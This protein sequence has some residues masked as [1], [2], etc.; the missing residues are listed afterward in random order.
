MSQH[1]S[2]KQQKLVVS[3]IKSW[4]ADSVIPAE[5]AAA[6]IGRY[7]PHAAAANIPGAL[8]IVGAVLVGLGTL[9]FIAANWQALAVAA[10]LSLICAGIVVS[11]YFGWRLSFEPGNRPKLGAALL[12]LGG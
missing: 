12:L 7:P 3:E 6:L 9:L 8:T 5:L 2:P 1:L 10:K 11:H 4:S